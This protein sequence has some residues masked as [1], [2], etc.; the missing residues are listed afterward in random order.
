M[1]QPVSFSEGVSSDVGHA[2]LRAAIRHLGGL[3]GES[4]TR[5][6]G[7][8]LLELVERVRHLARRH[9]DVVEL[10][11]VLDGV[12]TTTAIALA[13]AFTTYFQLAN[14]SEQLHR[15][16]ELSARPH[17]PLAETIGRIRAA[18]V[19][20]ELLRDIVSRLELRPVFTAHPTEASRRSVLDKQRRIADLLTVLD[21][22][23]LA[24]VERDRGERRLAELVDLLWETDELRIERPEP[25][26]EA[27]GAA[28][29]LEQLARHVVPNL[30]E[31][32]DA[33]LTAIGAPV[34]LRA[35]P[36][37]FGTW[38]GGDR[39]GN[40]AVTP[41]VTLEVLTLQHEMSLRVLISAVDA[42]TRDL[43][44]SSRI[45]DITPELSAS[46]AADSAALPGVEARYHRLNAAEPYRMKCNYIRQRLRNTRRRL[47]V[48]GPHIPGQ[49]YLGSTELL[50]D[51]ELMRAS[52]A[53]H[54]GGLIADGMLAHAMRTVA[55][56]GLHLG[57][58]DI[59]E[60]AARHHAALARLFDRLG[61]S[62]TPYAELDRDSRTALL[63]AELRSR[64]PLVGPDHRALGEPAAE[65]L[66]LFATIGIALDRFGD[67]VIESHI[68]S[69]TR[70]V[71]DVLAAVVLARE[72]GLVD[73]ALGRARIGFVPLLETVDE[74][75]RAG[76]ILEALLAEPSYR[77]IVSARGDVQEVMVGYSDSS[78]DAGITTSQWEIQKAQRHL[79]D[80]AQRH[81]I[82]LRVF[83]GRGGSV[84]RGGGPT[85]ESILAQPFGTLNGPMKLTEQG[86][87]ISD[88]YS[89]PGL[90]RHNLELTLAAV[91]EASVLH[92]TPRFS[93]ARLDAWEATVETVSGA[94][95]GAYRAL[96]AAPRLMPFFTTATPV[97]EL[98][99]LNI[100]SRPARR[101]GGSAAGV[102]D[103]RAVPWVFGW[104]QARIALPGWYGV[105]SGLAA[106]FDDGRDGM[107]A[108]M[109]ES[110]NFFRTFIGNVEMV[111]AK[112]DLEIAA[113]YVDGLVDPGVRPLFDIIRQEHARTVAAVLRVSG[114]ERLLDG[115]PVLRRTFE[116]RDA[117]LAPLH[118]LQIAL[119]RRFR[120]GDEPDL[121]LRRALL[122][123]VNGIAAGLRNTG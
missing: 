55:A 95:R 69:M 37:T 106:V 21:D 64:R 86:E 91:L 89:L 122:V 53:A 17:A 107:L 82:V 108:E 79:R 81:G 73:I 85:A 9:E 59:R 23:G 116:V 30:L 96:V 20:S 109:Y 57:T 19:D 25:T 92:R 26:D 18:H 66:E 36:L 49:D 47:A 87:V 56:F 120:A 54:H 38:T 27:R 103:M 110:W 42:L 83:H 16:R 97:D 58:M 76:D 5:H 77:R 88:K 74:L 71:D 100:G 115:N 118:A 62:S 65:L 8:E 68:I 80:V 113:R 117:Y 75:R 70:G 22:A 84:G 98:A 119:L 123:T 3:L 1:K 14:V 105:G 61:E 35:R 31:D 41:A 24:V 50:D 93:G 45:V 40:P 2:S 12:D 102:E 15:E 99:L 67:D 104:T 13:R 52:A 90:A 39:D 11:R 10:T 43:S 48:V 94:A 63:S 78:K 44:L 28:Y 34:A 111:L 7:H 114:Q 32:F 51:L 6:E 4:L 29:Y 33:A 72:A 101:P 112:T 60:H 121:D 46:L